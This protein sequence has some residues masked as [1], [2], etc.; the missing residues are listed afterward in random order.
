MVTWESTMETL[1]PSYMALHRS[2]ALSGRSLM[3]CTFRFTS[4]L[5]DGHGEGCDEIGKFKK[6]RIIGLWNYVHIQS[7]LD[8]HGIQMMFGGLSRLGA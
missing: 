3:G 7:C 6:S 8:I 4:A 1:Q 2:Q 5:R